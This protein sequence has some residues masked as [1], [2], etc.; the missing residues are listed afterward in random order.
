[1]WV[2]LCLKHQCSSHRFASGSP[3]DCTPCMRSGH[4]GGRAD[5]SGAGAGE[6]ASVGVAP[7]AYGDGHP[8]RHARQLQ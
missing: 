7:A 5:A 8:E 2:L 3:H 6:E 1:M 4:A